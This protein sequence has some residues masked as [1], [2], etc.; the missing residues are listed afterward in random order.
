[1]QRVRKLRR[2]DRKYNRVIRWD[3]IL[4]RLP[5]GPCTLV[6]VGVWDG[7][8]CSRL[9]A[10]HP[11]LHMVLVDPWK[12]PAAGTSFAESGA[13]QAELGQER[14]D[15]SYQ[16]CMRRV[17]PFAARVDVMRLSGKRA[18]LIVSQ[19]DRPADYPDAVFVDSDHSYEGVLEDV[20]AWVPLVKPGGWI[21][22][23][24]YGLPGD[25]GR[26]PGKYPGVARAVHDVFGQDRVTRGKDRTWFVQL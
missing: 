17:K 10:A 23:H 18:A 14:Y 6:E 19:E 15:V 24:D 9:L 22:G 16:R 12:A 5:E 1:M 26:G 3:E 2:L 11:E 13:E 8:T 7:G 25:T 20:T 4:A 21:G